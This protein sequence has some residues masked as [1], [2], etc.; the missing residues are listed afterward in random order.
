MQ[1]VKPAVDASHPLVEGILVRNRATG[2]RAVVMMNWAY[3]GH[4]L[5][6]RDNPT[7]TIRGAGDASRITAAWLEKQLPITKSPD[8]LTVTLPHLDEAEVL[9]LD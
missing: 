9:L 6:P 2:K 4:E 7:I 5:V 3:K 8:A 1:R